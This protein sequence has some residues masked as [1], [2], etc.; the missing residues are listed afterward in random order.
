M[1]EDR[2]LED[3]GLLEVRALADTADE[4]D[5]TVVVP[6]F[7]D[8]VLASIPPENLLQVLAAE[9]EREKAPAREN[10]GE[11][12]TSP[13]TSSVILKEEVDA[14]LAKVNRATSSIQ[15]SPVSRAA[16]E[17]ARLPRPKSYPIPQPQVVDNAIELSRGALYLL[18]AVTLMVGATLGLVFGAIVF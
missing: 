1:L 10:A 16:P 2:F 6:E 14:A 13:N 17:P 3:E 11:F 9:E 4:V 5:E 8:S 18:V 7:E 12:A 15:P